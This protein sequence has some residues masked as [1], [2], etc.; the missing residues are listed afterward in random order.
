MRSLIPIIGVQSAS[1]PVAERRVV[2]PWRG[3]GW[4]RHNDVIGT[5]GI[6]S[7][8]A[9]RVSG[10]GGRSGGDRQAGGGSSGMAPPVFGRPSLHRGE[11]LPM[12]GSIPGGSFCL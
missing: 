3:Q 9:G 10:R 6:V 8:T 11:F 4:R 2:R 5:S 12:K 1:C 7:G